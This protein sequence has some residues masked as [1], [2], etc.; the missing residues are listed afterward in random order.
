MFRNFAHAGMLTT[1]VF[2]GSALMGGTRVQA[3]FLEGQTL[4]VEVQD[5]KFSPP[6]TLPPIQFVVNDTVEVGVSNHPGI[7]NFNLE[8]TDNTITFTYTQFALF[9]TASFNG[10]IFRAISAG[11]PSFGSITV[12]PATTLA[13]FNSSRV[14]LDSK[15]FF[16]NVSGLVANSG[17]VLKLD[18]AQVP[19]PSSLAL[20]G[21]GLLLVGGISR[22]LSKHS[23][24]N[25]TNA[26]Q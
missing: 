13:G 3:D 20:I 4:S 11:I 17:T 24:P 26:C 21:M 16:V 7:V 1:I 6:L 9:D 25:A 22:R 23:K 10:Y 8:V 5:T 2:F 12:D 18:V 19:E 15:D 14:S